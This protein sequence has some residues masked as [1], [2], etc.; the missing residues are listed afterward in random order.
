MLSNL[1]VI[2]QWFRPRTTPMRKPPFCRDFCN[3]VLRHDI[4]SGHAT[5]P[6]LLFTKTLR[7]RNL[8]YAGFLFRLAAQ[9]NTRQLL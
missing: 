1:H 3:G 4:A 7:R 8:S 2:F 5:K 6:I 9:A